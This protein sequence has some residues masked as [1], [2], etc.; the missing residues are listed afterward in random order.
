MSDTDDSTWRRLIRG[1]RDGDGRCAQEF[2]DRYGPGLHQLA[3]G[4]MNQRLRRRVS[5]EDVVQSVCRTFLRRAQ[6]GQFA[7]GDSEDLWRLLCAITLTKVREQARY[8]GRHKRGM[9]QEVHG[10]PTAD[11]E[12]TGIEAALTADEPSPAEAVEF[13]D[14]FEQLLASLDAEERQIVDLV[15]QDHTQ[16]EIAHKLGTSERTV[17]RVFKR[18]KSRLARLLAKE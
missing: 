10:L 6:Q 18:V 8:H 17:R 15:L 1:L 9:D 5:P 14:Y 12:Q 2:W 4:R 3:E 16:P 13:A 11:E 7:L